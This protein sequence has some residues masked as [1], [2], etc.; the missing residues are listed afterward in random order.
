MSGG[1]LQVAR[2]LEPPATLVTVLPDSGAK[3]MSKIYNDEWIAANG[4]D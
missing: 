3:Y 2:R 4:L 1:C